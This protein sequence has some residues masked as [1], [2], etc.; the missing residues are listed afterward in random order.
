MYIIGQEVRGRQ[1]I[2]KQNRVILDI[3]SRVHGMAIVLLL[4]R[5][6]KTKFTF[7]IVPVGPVHN[8]GHITRVVM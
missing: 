1:N 7:I 2:H 6:T 8:Y 5:H 4:V 3:K